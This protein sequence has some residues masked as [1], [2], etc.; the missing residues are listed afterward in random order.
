MN[1]YD[2]KFWI[3]GKQRHRRITAA[4]KSDVENMIAVERLEPGISIRWSEAFA[5]FKQFKAQ[6]GKIT[7]SIENT[8]RAVDAFI[9]LKGDIDISKTSPEI[10]KDFLI[11]YA[12]LTPRSTADA[13]N[14]QRKE[15]LTVARFTRNHTGRLTSVPFEN[16][17][18]LPAKVNTRA[19]IPT[20]QISDYIDA[21]PE[22]IR[23]PIMMILF[24]GLRSTATCNINEDDIQG[25]TLYAVDK[26]DTQ[27]RIPI[28]ETL[29]EIL[30]QAK[31][32]KRTLERKRINP[33]PV[34][35]NLH[36]NRWIARTL[37]TAAQAAWKDAGLKPVKIHELRH[38]LGT[39][40]GKFFPVGIIQVLMG[41]KSRKSSE[42]YFH[43]HEEMAVEA[44]KKLVRFV[45]G[46]GEKTGQNS[47]STET[48]NAEQTRLVSCPCCGHNFFVTNE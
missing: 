46:L 2:V 11:K 17:P 30:A 31:E 40:A 7:R 45:S 27:R 23:R 15:L 9:K 19:P 44:R 36:G 41:H 32:F 47:A 1:V 10:F 43:P 21:L 18:K 8:E 25:D 48:E 4:S 3:G 39:Q 28:D 16:V 35:V 5:L 6:D 24:Y 37:L 22:Y 14:H 26:G 38:T 12:G 13:A 20:N 29:A 33:L 34:F 42:T